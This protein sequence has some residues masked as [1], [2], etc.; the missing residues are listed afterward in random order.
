[1]IV[2]DLTH[3]PVDS[4]GASIVAQEVDA[5]EG[6]G[7]VIDVGRTDFDGDEND[8]DSSATVGTASGGGGS[9]QPG[10]AD[11]SFDFDGGDFE[12]TPYPEEED[13][14][15]DP[16]EEEVDAVITGYDSG[17][18]VDAGDTLEFSPGCPN[19]KITWYSVNSVTGEKEII[20]GP[21]VGTTLDGY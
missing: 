3:F 19:P 13:N 18:G 1:M 11:T 4:Q 16:L 20:K 2:Y 8:A 10:T 15:E 12:D 21:G 17:S 7:N 9:N 14:P 5:A 6:A